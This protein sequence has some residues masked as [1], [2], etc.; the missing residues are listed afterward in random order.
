[1]VHYLYLSAV[2]TGAV[3][4]QS[5]NEEVK[6]I[7]I[8]TK[9]ANIKYPIQKT[10]INSNGKTIHTR[11]VVPEGF[12]RS[13]EVQN[14]F[15]YY[16]QH[17]PVKP[18]GSIVKTY[19][20]GTKANNEVYVAVIDLPIGNKDL[21]QCADAVMRLRMD[22]LYGQKRYDEIHFNFTNGF[23]VDYS[24]YLKGNRMVVSGNNTI[25]HY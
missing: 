8:S 24:E 6:G 15:A 20:G 7:A 3:F 18:K 14:S 1:M 10:K 2:I 11:I 5:C 4:L 17:L 9:Q 21:H 25:Y 23:R 19:N 13:T 22:Y 12:E 16:L